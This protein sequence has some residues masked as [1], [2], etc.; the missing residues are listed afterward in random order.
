MPDGVF[1]TNLITAAR[2]SLNSIEPVLLSRYTRSFISLLRQIVFE[3]RREP[4]PIRRE[5][6]LGVEEGLGYI[7]NLT[8]LPPRQDPKPFVGIVLGNLQALHENSFGPLDHD[9]IIQPLLDIG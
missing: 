8:A 9:S 4:I 1:R 7:A 2:K 5:K 3:V 6:E